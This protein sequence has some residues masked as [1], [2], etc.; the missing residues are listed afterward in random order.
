MPTLRQLLCASLASSLVLSAGTAEARFGKRSS[1]SS[2]KTHDASPVG[3]SDDDD[4]GG[5]SSGSSSGS[6]NAVNAVGTILDMLFFVAHVA[7]AAERASSH[8]PTTHYETSSDTS[9][10]DTSYDDTSYEAPSEP[11]AMEPGQT[12]MYAYGQEPV[13]VRQHQEPEGNRNPL[14]FRLGLEGQSL[15]AGSSVGLNVGLEGQRWGVAAA[16]TSL[17][18][19]TDDGT[20]GEDKIDLFSAH[21]TFALYTSD[22]ARL[23]VEGGMAAAKAPDITL[24]GPSFAL[25]FERCLFGA[26]DMEARGQIVPVPHIQVDAQAGLALR[27]NALTLRTGWRVQLLDDRGLVD[28][29]VHRDY[30]SGPYAGIGLYF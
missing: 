23:R 14:M 29:V 30:F 16:A 28:G 22:R 7:D 1:S 4:S 11:V 3:S 2:S 15:G 26:L 9:Y 21:L 25:S 20:A 8:E 24:A 12:P 13:A 5:S 18:L 6:S 17:R 10:V 27:L 19:P